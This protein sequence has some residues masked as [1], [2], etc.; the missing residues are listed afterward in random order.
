MRWHG[1]GR[2]DGE[3]EEEG[4]GEISHGSDPNR[5]EGASGD[6]CCFGV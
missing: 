6:V 5:I 3:E 2:R 4:G 1:G